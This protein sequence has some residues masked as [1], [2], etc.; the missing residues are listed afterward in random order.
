MGRLLSLHLC[1]PHRLARRPFSRLAFGCLWDG[2]CPCA[3]LCQPFALTTHAD[4]GPE[5][6][7]VA[8]QPA[9]TRDCV[10]CGRPASWDGS[11]P[12]PTT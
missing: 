1:N 11:C 6:W 7:H 3:P 2:S 12:W 8:S 10:P 9:A 5:R 4:G